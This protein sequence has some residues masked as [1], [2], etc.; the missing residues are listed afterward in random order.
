MA[1]KWKDISTCPEDKSVLVCGGILQSELWS[2]GLAAHPE[3]IKVQK[4]G[5]RFDVQ[6]TCYYSVWVENPTHWCDLPVVAE[7]DL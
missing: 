5:S 3:P 6:D 4:S 1:K 7:F 2:G